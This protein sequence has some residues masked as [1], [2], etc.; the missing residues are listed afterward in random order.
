MNDD[1]NLNKKHLWAGIHDEI[2]GFL[3][4]MTDIHEDYF[5]NSY[6]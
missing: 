3:I 5:L 4:F 2:N 6:V 1:I